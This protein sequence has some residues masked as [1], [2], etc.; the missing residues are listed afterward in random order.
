MIARGVQFIDDAEFGRVEVLF[1]ARNRRV[2]ARS[3]ADGTVRMS[4]PAAMSPSQACDALEKMRPQ[5]RRLRTKSAER[6]MFFQPGVAFRTHFRGLSIQRS[7]RPRH[8]QITSDN[9]NVWICNTDDIQSSEIQEHITTA[10]E[11]ALRSEARFY[12]PRRTAE[13]ATKHGFQI[14]R[15]AIRRTVSRWGSCS[16][17]KNLSFSLFLM[18]LPLDLIDHVIL[19]ELCHTREMNHG[20]AFHRLLAQVDPLSR[21]HA[22]RVGAISV[23][24][25][26]RLGAAGVG[27]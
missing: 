25:S 24:S 1:T 18:M 2:V 9:I 23:E 22:R 21:S 13:L 12:L 6:R 14:G 27:G 3:A 8:F 26:L 10:V 4:A 7:T 15:V 5:I 19:H 11:T 17:S 16:S 20:P